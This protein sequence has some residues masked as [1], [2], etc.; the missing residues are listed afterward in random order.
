MHKNIEVWNSNLLILYLKKWSNALKKMI[1]CFS[2]KISHVFFIIKH[3][4]NL[5]K[6]NQIC[7][8]NPPL[9]TSEEVDLSLISY[10]CMHSWKVRNNKASIFRTNGSCDTLSAVVCVDT[11]SHVQSISILPPYGRAPSHE[12]FHLEYYRKKYSH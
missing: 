8:K 12:G 9:F 4:P 2:C 6:I 11:H 1:K 5:T 3:T 7:K 10:S